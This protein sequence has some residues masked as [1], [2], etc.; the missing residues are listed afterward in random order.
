M[1]VD[2]DKLNKRANTPNVKNHGIQRLTPTNVSYNGIPSRT[3]IFKVFNFHV[4]K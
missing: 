2:L 1:D 3:F 4:F